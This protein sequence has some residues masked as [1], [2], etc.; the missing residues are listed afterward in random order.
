MQGTEVPG[1]RLNNS[2][3]TQISQGINADRTIATTPTIEKEDIYDEDVIYQK[4]KQAVSGVRWKPSVGYFIHHHITEIEE[5]SQ[6]L[7]NGTYAPRR[8]KFFR[9]TEPKPRTIMSVHIKDRIYLRA[10]N[11]IAIYPQITKSLIPDNFACQKGKGTDPARKRLREFLESYYRHY[12]CQ[13]YRLQ[14]DIHGYYPNM[15][16]EYAKSVF[17]KRMTNE[18]YPL[19]EQALGYHP[20]EIGF[21]PGDQTIQNVGIAALDDLD[22]FIKERMRIKYYIR[23]MD[24]FILFHPDREYLMHCYSEIEK[25]LSKQ[26]MT[27]NPTKT[28]IQPISKPML[29]LG[30]VYGLMKTGKVVILVDPRKIK[31]ERKKLRRMADHVLKNKPIRKKKRNIFISKHDVDIHFRAYKATIRF[32]NSRKVIYNLNRFYENLWKGQ[33]HE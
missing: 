21:S 14:V 32:G 13:G 8:P 29:F 5:L 7:R 19:A 31:H 15:N 33:N 6:T 9:I 28:E 24:D 16:R 20:G 22:H 4:M 3:V 2:M 27:I 1:E 18:T 23:Y 17:R 10:L 25:F 30:F 12:G 11:D 26:R